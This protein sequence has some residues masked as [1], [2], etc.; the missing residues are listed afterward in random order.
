[1]T[2]D[3]TPEGPGSELGVEALLGDELDCLFGELDLES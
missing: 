3:G 1:V 2:L